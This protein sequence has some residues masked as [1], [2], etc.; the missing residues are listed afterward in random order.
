[1]YLELLSK[2]NQRLDKYSQFRVDNGILYKYVRC[3]IP[4]LSSD[5][6]YW[7]IVVPKDKRKDL[8]H[9]Y[10]NDVRSRHVGIYKVYWKLHN[11]YFWPKMRSDI[12]KYIKGCRTCA[13]Y[14]PEQKSPRGHMRK[15]PEIDKPWEMLS[16]NYL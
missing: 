10:H 1:M 2:I 6:D 14:R 5:S 12:A 7:K 8:I 16:L 11:F 3:T 4:E 13:A 9:T 15:R